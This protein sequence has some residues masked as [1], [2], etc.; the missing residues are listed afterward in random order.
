M[1]SPVTVV[2]SERWR[3]TV[4]GIKVELP[5]GESL[6]TTISIGVAG[7][8]AGADT[9]VDVVLRADMALYRAKE[10]GRNRVCT[11]ADTTG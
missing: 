3:E 7:W 4:E 6:S 9:V 2:H 5:T 11:D 1:F 8:H 10:T